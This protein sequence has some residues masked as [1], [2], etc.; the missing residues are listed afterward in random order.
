MYT[1]RKLML[2]AIVSE[3]AICIYVCKMETLAGLRYP[4]LMMVTACRQGERGSISDSGC[5]RVFCP[6][7]HV[8]IWLSAGWTNCVLFASEAETSVCRRVQASCGV[9]PDSFS[10]VHRG[11]IPLR[12]SYWCL[13]VT[14]HSYK[15]ACSCTSYPHV[16]RHGA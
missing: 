14:V 3:P 11:L 16:I 1:S 13:S 4:H 7:V 8:Y 6:C 9:H 15:K 2:I 5:K 12:Y 10:N